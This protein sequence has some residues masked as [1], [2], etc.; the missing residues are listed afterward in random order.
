MSR[1]PFLLFGDGPRLRSGLAR[2]ARDLAVRLYAEQEELG[3][4]F[5]Q[6]GVDDPGGWHWQPWDFFGFQPSAQEQGWGVLKTIERQ[7]W[8]EGETERPIV[9]AIMDPARVYDLTS[10]HPLLTG[11]R[12]PGDTQLQMDLWGYFPIDA[13][14]LAGAVGGPAAE[15]IRTADRLLAYGQYGAGVLK[16]TLELAHVLKPVAWLPHGL[17]PGVFTPEVP[18]TEAPASWQQWA[19][20]AEDRDA[21]ILGC[22]ATNQWRK[23]LGL[24][25]LVV[26]TLRQR[27]QR[28]AAWLQTDRFTNAWDI[29]ELVASLGLTQ[30]EVY[31]STDHLSDRQLAAQYAASDVTIAPGLGEGF[32]YPIV[33]SLACGTPVVHGA[34][35]G[36]TDLVPRGWQILPIALRLD[37]CYALQRPVFVAAAWADRV[38]QICRGTETTGAE[39]TAFC[40]GSVAHLSWQAL[41]PRWRAWI[42]Q[43]LHQRREQPRG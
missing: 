8:E 30:A 17:E 18:V 24:Y 1:I 37:G 39:Q 29:G 2:I 42:T 19:R 23:D 41:W 28:V 5:M 25:F 43:G 31:A 33:E 14:N 10:A 34:Y 38:E 13:H 9:L 40:T 35:A 3:I 36:G 32:G 20:A 21:L 6:V 16:K 7:L 26:A 27:G 12:E 4:R 22:V 11:W 15:A